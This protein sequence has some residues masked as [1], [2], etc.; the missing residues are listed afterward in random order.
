MDNKKDNKTIKLKPVDNI[1]KV[2]E[3]CDTDLETDKVHQK[4][5]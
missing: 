5:I 4:A 3:N 2:L 1:K